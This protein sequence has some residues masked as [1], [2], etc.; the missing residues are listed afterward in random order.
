MCER[1]DTHTLPTTTMMMVTMLSLPLVLT[2]SVTSWALP[3]T[4]PPDT[5]V[6]FWR[7][8]HLPDNSKELAINHLDPREL[9]TAKQS[10]LLAINAYNTHDPHPRWYEERGLTEMYAVDADGGEKQFLV[11]FHVAETKCPNSRERF[12]HA[13]CA[14]RENAIRGCCMASVSALSGKGLKANYVICNVNATGN[15]TEFYW[16]SERTVVSQDEPPAVPAA[17]TEAAIQLALYNMTS[18]VALIL[19]SLNTNLWHIQYAQWIR[20]EGSEKITLEVSS[21]LTTSTKVVDPRDETDGF[22]PSGKMNADCTTTVTL[23]KCSN[24]NSSKR[25]GKRCDSEP[26]LAGTSGWT[27]E[28]VESDCDMTCSAAVGGLSRV[29]GGS[30]RCPKKVMNTKRRLF[31]CR[32]IACQ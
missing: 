26:Q 20:Q 5:C 25:S 18:S 27:L 4:Q 2:L 30:G 3:V 1:A 23:A 7:S 13:F 22:C 32:S 21:T 6:V 10:V 12:K 24:S 8:S 9:M 28:D 15:E 11:T 29:S 31:C 17:V 14:D 19:D 16:V